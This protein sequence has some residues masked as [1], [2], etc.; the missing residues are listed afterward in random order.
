[1]IRHQSLGLVFLTPVALMMTDFVISTPAQQLIRDRVWETTLGAAV[2][3]TLI[4]TTDPLTS[5]VGA[6]RAWRKGS[7]V[8]PCGCSPRP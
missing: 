6:L 4:L 2:A 7:G 3:M 8:P 1:M 5:R